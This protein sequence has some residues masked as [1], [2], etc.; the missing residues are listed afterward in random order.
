MEQ[1]DDQAREI[2]ELRDRLSRLS[3]A[4]LRINESLDFDTVL[5][6][7]LDSACSLTGARYGVITLLNE[8]GR[9]QDFLYSG[10]TP[11]ESRR[12]AEFPNGMLFFEYLSSISEPLRLRDFHSYVRGVGLPEF[13][14]PMA[15]STPLPFLAAPIRH[16]GESVGAFYV[17]EKEL[18]FTPED[19]ETLVMFASQT[20]LVIAN[21]RRHRDEQRARA[22]LETLIDTSPVGVL[23]FDAKTGGVR[24]RSTGRRGGSSA[25]CARPA[26]RR[27]SC[28][29]C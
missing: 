18:E 17:G 19:E 14:P 6:G 29:K 22:D 24:R 23:V 26:A 7:V 27:S 9:I 12:F 21:A 20:A 25:T 11:E 10:L 28:S 15:V 8:S 1:A 2:A 3:Q 4:S 5:Q 13:H 16:L